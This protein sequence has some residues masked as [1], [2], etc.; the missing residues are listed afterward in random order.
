MAWLFIHILFLIGFRN[1]IVV[2]FEWAWGYL[3]WKKSGRILI[4]DVAHVRSHT[5]LHNPPIPAP[6]TTPPVPNKQQLQ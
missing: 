5:A 4:G 6:E 3:T 1:R 2:L